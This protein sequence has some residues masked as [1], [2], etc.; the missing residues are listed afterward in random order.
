[1]TKHLEHG[2]K[3]VALVTGAA[4]R[5]GA[6][7]ARTLHRAGY[8]IAVHYGHSQSEAQALCHQLNRERPDSAAALQANLNQLEQIDNLASQAVALWGRIDALI[9]NASSFYPTPI[10][11]TG[12]REWNDLIG[13]NL[14]A[15]FFLA[16]ALTPALKQQRGCI[17][18]IA[19]IHAE[20]PLKNHTLYCAAKAGNVMLTKSLAKELAPHI[21]VNGIAPGAILWPE[22]GDGELPPAAQQNILDRIPLERPGDPADIARTVVFLLCHAPYITGQVLAVDGGRNLSS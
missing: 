5:I 8:N 22:Q 4:R 18:N 9:N 7:I 16:Q 11:Q 3:P 6:D 19:D 1:M 21:R 2:K 14:K 12:E 17:I 20:R 15:P 13:S 10:G